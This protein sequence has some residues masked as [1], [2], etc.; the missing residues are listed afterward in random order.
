MLGKKTNKTLKSSKI[1]VYL[2]WIH[3]FK[4]A[5][6]LSLEENLQSSEL[7]YSKGFDLM[8]EID[9]SVFFLPVS[10]ISWATCTGCVCLSKR[11]DQVTSRGPFQS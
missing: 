8:L 5:T 1:A 11:L 6:H 9:T 2:C 10:G 4:I 3:Y 7:H